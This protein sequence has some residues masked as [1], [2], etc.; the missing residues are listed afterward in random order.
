MK[1][2]P[3]VFLRDPENMA[4]VT[5]TVHPDCQWVLDGEGVATRKYDG[6]CTLFDGT[7]WWARREV[8]RGKKAPD[9]FVEADFDPATGKTVGWEPMSQSPFAKFHAE[10]LEPLVGFG[11]L[12][13]QTVPV[14]TYELIGP[15]INGNPEGCQHHRLERHETV[16]Q[17]ADVTRTYDGL[18]QYAVALLREE[19]IEGIVFHHPDGRM[20]KIKGKDF[21]S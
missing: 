13:G 6:T 17:F 1:K 19:G 14:G 21:P 8:K 7:D 20:A 15:K 9:G 3:T 4:R 5:T 10:A 12:I 11:A 18:R 16:E 2:I